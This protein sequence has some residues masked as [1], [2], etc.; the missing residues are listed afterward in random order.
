MVGFSLMILAC[1]TCF[2]SVFFLIQR[3]S[4]LLHSLLFSLFALLALL[5]LPSIQRPALAPAAVICTIV[6]LVVGFDIARLHHGLYKSSLLRS[7]FTLLLFFFCSIYLFCIALPASYVKKG[8]YLEITSSTPNHKKN[9]AALTYPSGSHILLYDRRSSPLF[10]G[11]LNIELLQVRIRFIR[12]PL[13][14]TRLGIQSPWKIDSLR[15][16]TLKSSGPYQQNNSISFIDEKATSLLW[17]L[18]ERGFLSKTGTVFGLECHLV[19]MSI[20]LQDSSGRIRE[21]KFHLYLDKVGVLRLSKDP[22]P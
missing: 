10:N 11:D 1:A 7:L 3:Q 17:Q 14:L 4:I 15:P 6:M 22:P 21:G 12:L 8:F 18:W 20:P 2:R 5:L 9:S 19:S 13:W 16:D